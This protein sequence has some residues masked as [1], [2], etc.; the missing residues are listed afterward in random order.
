M[1]IQNHL[2]V[3]KICPVP[4]IQ[5]DAASLICFPLK[6]IMQVMLIVLSLYH[7][8][9]HSNTRNLYPCN[10]ILIDCSKSVKIYFRQTL[11][12]PRRRI[13]GGI[14]AQTVESTL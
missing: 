14:S 6:G 5:K 10:D 7:R 11:F 8:V 9:I 1:A 2:A 12:R 13:T 3:S 4:I